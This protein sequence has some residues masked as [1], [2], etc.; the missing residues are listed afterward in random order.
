M[1]ILDFRLVIF[2]ITYISDNGVYLFVY[3]YSKPSVLKKDSTRGTD[4]ICNVKNFKLV[5]SRSDSYK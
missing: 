2:K 1:F 3:E 4:I 5:K